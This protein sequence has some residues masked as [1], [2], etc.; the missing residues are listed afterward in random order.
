MVVPLV[1]FDVDGEGNGF[2]GAPGGGIGQISEPKSES[3]YICCD[4]II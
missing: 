4:A 1:S 3:S 2:I